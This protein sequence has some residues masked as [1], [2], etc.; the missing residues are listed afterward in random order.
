MER[1]SAQDLNMVLAED[2]G[3]PQDIGALAILDGSQLPAAGGRFP[4]EAVRDPM[5]RS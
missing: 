2:F 4:I 5:P 1:L 3:W